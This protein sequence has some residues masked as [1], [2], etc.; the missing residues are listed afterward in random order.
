MFKRSPCMAIE[1]M[2]TESRLL[3]VVRT[4]LW[5]KGNLA[6]RDFE[7]GINSFNK[8]TKADCTVI[9]RF[10]FCWEES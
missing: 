7:L 3:Q 5:M 2:L 9:K 6:V 4:M 10:D 1:E 8:Y